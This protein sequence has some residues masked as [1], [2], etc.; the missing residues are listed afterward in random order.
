MGQDLRGNS[1]SPLMPC[2]RWCN[3]STQQVEAGGLHSSEASQDSGVRS[4]AGVLGPSNL[5]FL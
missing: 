4:V 2:G 3:D 1:K 5:I